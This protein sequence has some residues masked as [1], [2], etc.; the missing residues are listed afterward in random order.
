MIVFM[1]V[2]V[3]SIVLSALEVNTLGLGLYSSILGE[4]SVQMNQNE[5][6]G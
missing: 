4:V 6:V 3:S 5:Y 2:L 1:L